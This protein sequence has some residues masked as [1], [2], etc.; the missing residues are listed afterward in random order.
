MARIRT[1]KPEFFRHEE[2]Q[3]LEA[4]NVGK[5]PMMVFAGLW[6]H[7]DK[8]GVFAYKPRSLKL[9]ILPFLPFDMTETL[10]ILEAAGFVE[11]FEVEGE[12]YGHIR[13][14]P[15]HQRITGKEA[16]QS[17]RHP[18][19]IGETTGK[20]L[21]NSGEK[22]D[23]QERKG[24]EGKGKEWKG[25]DIGGANAPKHDGE[26]KRGSRLSENWEPD[27]KDIDHAEGRGFDAATIDRMAEAFRNHHIAKGTVSKCWN[28]SWRT[29]CGNEIRY[30]GPPKPPDT[31]TDAERRQ[32]EREAMA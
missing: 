20:H 29:W 17:G 28:A 16:E 23:A 31:L 27:G 25:K 9:D 24:K 12:K 32:I 2:L 5:Y 30:H 1:V 6:G 8:N 19:P 26:K 7:C 22:P 10:E 15:E 18:E 3:D 11:V 14:F 13:S 4:A 21:G